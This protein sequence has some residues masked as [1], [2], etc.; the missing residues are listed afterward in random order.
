MDNENIK[1][2]I[3]CSPH[4]HSPDN[5]RSIMLDVVIAL[6]PAML[7]AIFFFGLRALLVMAVS[8]A[9]C[10]VFEYLYR[11]LLKKDTTIGDCSAIVT[12]ILLALV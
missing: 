12:G 5:T 7:G 10:V 8:V 9:A 2:T 4:V 3:S 6:I 1:L 11:R